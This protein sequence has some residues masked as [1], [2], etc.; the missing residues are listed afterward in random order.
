MV[1]PEFPKEGSV[2][3]L[4]DVAQEGIFVLILPFSLW[5]YVYLEEGLLLLEI[6]LLPQK[7]TKCMAPSSYLAWRELN[8]A[9]LSKERPQTF[10]DSSEIPGVELSVRWRVHAGVKCVPAFSSLCT[11]DK[12]PA[13]HT[14]TDRQETS[15]HAC[16][17]KEETPG[18][19]YLWLTTP[20]NF[21]L[22]IFLKIFKIYV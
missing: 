16:D 18:C 12:T 2:S 1:T 17:L 6:I 7:D 3:L 9:W 15:S 20:L 5:L 10:L 11:L 13:P 21:Y 19:G 14:P 8:G 22:F 4:E